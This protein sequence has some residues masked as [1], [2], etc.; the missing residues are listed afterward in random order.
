M[1]H[2]IP[3]GLK[4]SEEEAFAILA[5]CLTSPQ[6]LDANSEKA[7]RKLAEYCT[8]HCTHIESIKKQ[9]VQL[10]AS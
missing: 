4:L 9:Q 6:R 5:L 1:T 8:K 3:E 2:G 7:L 10:S